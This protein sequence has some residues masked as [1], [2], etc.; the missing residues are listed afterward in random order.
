M[1]TQQ[2]TNLPQVGD[3]FRHFKEGK[4]YVIVGYVHDATNGADTTAKILYTPQETLYQI[5][6]NYFCRNIK[7]FLSPV[8]KTKY[9]DATQSF[10]FEK[11]IYHEIG[12]DYPI[13]AF[14]E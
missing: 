12:D 9:P 7:E 5:D 8:D 10:R 4:L 13:G 2:M 6:R 11:V 1:C 14:E 3:V